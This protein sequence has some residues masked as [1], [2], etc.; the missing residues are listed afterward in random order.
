MLSFLEE[1]TSSATSMLERHQKLL[2][3]IV[4]AAQD[5]D[6]GLTSVQQVLSQN[7]ELLDSLFLSFLRD[8]VSRVS[9]TNKVLCDLIRSV[10][11]LVRGELENL[12]AEDANAFAQL[13][14]TKDEGSMKDEVKALVSA[15]DLYGRRRLWG[16]VQA[17]KAEAE[18]I[19]SRDHDNVLLL[20]SIMEA[21]LLQLLNSED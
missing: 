14:G 11:E 10:E 19:S 21:E 15:R 13:L 9:E 4:L 12:T 17:V 16:T 1:V 18:G 6:S 2:R 20:A 5:D 7:R 3:D 8:E